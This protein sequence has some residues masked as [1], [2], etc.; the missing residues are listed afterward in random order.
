[1]SWTLPGLKET[2]LTFN[3]SNLLDRDPPRFFTG[4]NNGVIGFDPQ[5]ASALGRVVSLGLRK[6]W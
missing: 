3:V 4:G 5:A 6:A 1:V 2:Q